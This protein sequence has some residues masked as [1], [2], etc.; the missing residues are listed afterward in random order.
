MKRQIN[1]AIVGI[2]VLSIALVIVGCAS[3]PKLG[4]PTTLQ[5]T[6]NA[7]PEISIAGKSLKFEFGGNT[8]IAQVNGENYIAGT[9]KSEDTG[10]GSI[11]TLK[12]T[13]AWRVANA[14]ERA[15]SGFD[16][17]VGGTLFLATGGSP[18]KLAE[19][20]ANKRRYLNEKTWKKTSGPD[21]VLEYKAG[22]SATLSRK[23]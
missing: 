3:E 1:S 23:L 17:V 20:E 6:L 14:G 8:W 9:F 16:T 15:L 11:L 22:S 19:L 18:N 10:D 7:M 21:I 2:A 5:Y 12:Q 4:S 13:H